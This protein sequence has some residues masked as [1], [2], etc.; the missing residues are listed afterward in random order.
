[1][2][3]LYWSRIIII[4]KPAVTAVCLLALMGC[5]SAKSAID[6]SA[7]QVRDLSA[8]SE[9]RFENIGGLAESSEARFE[10]SGDLDGVAE[11]QG[12]ASQAFSGADEQRDVQGLSDSIR[13]D[14]HGV[15]D[16]I[17]WWANMTTTVAIVI[18]IV[19]V[20]V[21]LWRSGILGFIRSFFW[22]LGLLI[23]KRKL[24]EVELDLKV[25]DDNSPTTFRESVA[26]KRASDPSYEAAYNKVKGRT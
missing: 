21:F 3:M 11:Q 12:I 1:M 24:Q 25:L 17:P 10:K 7:V 20:F 8:S 16:T 19:V 13:T 2:N 15:E 4:C 6:S 5:W 23:P 9:Q 14:L 26:S 18:G 22:G